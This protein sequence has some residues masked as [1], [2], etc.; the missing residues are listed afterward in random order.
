M[1]YGGRSVPRGLRSFQSMLRKWNIFCC[2]WSQE[3]FFSIFSGICRHTFHIY[4]ANNNSFQF[5]LFSHCCWESS[6]NLFSGE[7]M[8]EG[9]CEVS[10]ICYEKWG[11][12]VLF[13]VALETFLFDVFG[14]C[15]HATQ[16][17]YAKKTFSVL[18]VFFLLLLGVVERCVLG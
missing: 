3:L 11:T 2:L 1:F 5:L 7:E 14:I 13:F 16:T 12:F 8:P 18:F 9:V 10:K 6:S 15:R 17:Y 4:Y